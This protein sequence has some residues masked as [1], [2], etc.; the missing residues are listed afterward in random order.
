MVGVVAAGLMAG[1]RD[2]VVE[3]DV[4]VVE[5]LLLVVL[6]A[7]FPVVLEEGKTG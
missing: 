1:V 3:R 7:A 5:C 2:M 4:L 6:V